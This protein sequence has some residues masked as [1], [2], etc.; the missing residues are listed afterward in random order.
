LVNGWYLPAIFFK[1]LIMKKL[2]VLF[3][4]GASLM[5]Q[6]QN[7]F[8]IHAGVIAA[9]LTET[10]EGESDFN[11]KSRISFRAGVH[12]NLP[13]SP[14]FSIMPQLNFVSKGTKID[15]SETLDFMG[16]TYSYSATGHMKMN[17]LELPVHF[18]YNQK[19]AKGNTFFIGIG[20]SFSY[21]LS[22]EGKIS[23]YENDNGVVDQYTETVKLKF[24]GKDNATTN[25]EYAH[26]KAVEVGMSLIAG[27]Q[28][29]NMFVNAHFNQGLSNINPDKTDDGKTKTM[30]VGL[31]LGFYLSK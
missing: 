28:F 6:A 17:Y 4:A 30:Y 7:K 25:D 24:D 15:Q 20:P 9:D 16:A 23:V 22:G 19:M 14:M 18:V 8:G 27:Y 21:G 13:L 3:F 10:Y 1:P 26:Y 2:L 31:G 12:A 11:G 5:S 29:K